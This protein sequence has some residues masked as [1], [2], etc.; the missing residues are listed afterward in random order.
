MVKALFDTNILIDYLNAVPQALAELDHQN[1]PAISAVTWIE[2]LVGASA[3]TETATRRF[4]G[5]FDL[6][7]LDEVISERAVLLR[8]RHRLKI[9]DA[10][11][12]ASAQ[13]TGRVFVT[14]DVKDF[15]A[16][17]P[18]IRIPYTL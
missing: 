3:S 14:R 1:D 8:R 11:A 9:A 15:S 2:I 6:I 18:G 10:I 12:W 17:D 4:L 5:R 13:V 7:P 16:S